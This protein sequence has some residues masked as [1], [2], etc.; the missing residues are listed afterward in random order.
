MLSAVARAAVSTLMLFCR[1]VSPDCRAV[2]SALKAEVV[3]RSAAVTPPTLAA[4]TL[5]TREPSPEKARAVAVPLKLRSPF[6][7][8]TVVA[9]AIV[10]AV[11]IVG[12]EDKNEATGSLVLI[13]LR[14][15]T[16]EVPLSAT[17]RTEGLKG[18]DAVPENVLIPADTVLAVTVPLVVTLPVVLR[19]P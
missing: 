3:A 6:V 4:F 13:T 14:A 10:P 5:V 17:V 1:A 2:V 18:S 12:P 19:F 15:A 7:L 16:P 11:N 9:P 8:K